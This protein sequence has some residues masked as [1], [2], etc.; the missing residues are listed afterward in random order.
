MIPSIATVC[1]SGTLREKLEAI[2]AAGFTAVEIFENDLIAFPGS[3][4]EIKAICADLGL[5]IVTCKTRPWPSVRHTSST[6]A[7]PCARSTGVI[8]SMMRSRGKPGSF[9]KANMNGVRLCGRPWPLPEASLRRASRE[10]HRRP[11]PKKNGSDEDPQWER[12]PRVGGLV[13]VSQVG[14]PAQGRPCPST[15]SGPQAK[16]SAFC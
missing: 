6:P 16:L 1:V 12:Y 15:R 13:H 4:A 11:D 8:A 10:T 9:S 14:R 2:A 3:P 7:S 5:S